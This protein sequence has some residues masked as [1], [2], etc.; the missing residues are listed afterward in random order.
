METE[1]S[2]SLQSIVNCS[3]SA[4]LPLHFRCFY[5]QCNSCPGLIL[6]NV[7]FNENLISIYGISLLM[8]ILILILIPA[9]MAHST[10]D[11]ETLYVLFFV[12]L[13]AFPVGL[14]TIYFI[15]NP[16]H[17]LIAVDVLPCTF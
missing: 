11:P 1:R 15:L 5:L 4:L 16:K 10:K 14:P 6:N 8:G 2:G 9:W 13:T 17:F 12:L 7:R 3:D